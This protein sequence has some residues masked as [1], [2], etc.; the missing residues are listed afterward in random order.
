MGFQTLNITRLVSTRVIRSFT[1]TRVFSLLLFIVLYGCFCDNTDGGVA[2][3]SCWFLALLQTRVFVSKCTPCSVWISQMQQRAA[4]QK[5]W[6]LQK[7][8]AS[9]APRGL[10]NI[11]GLTCVFPNVFRWMA[12]SQSASEERLWQNVLSQLKDCGS[13]KV[14]FHWL[15]D[16]V[17]SL[18]YIVEA[19]YIRASFRTRRW[20]IRSSELSDVLLNESLMH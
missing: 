9:D 2:S 4:R 7:N 1:P 13:F 18:R 5:W 3:C 17:M 20:D 8:T 12:T 6:R 14:Y 16:A 19:G 15:C 10:N 11:R